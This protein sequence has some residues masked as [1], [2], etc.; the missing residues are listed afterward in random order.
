MSALPDAWCHKHLSLADKTNFFRP[1]AQEGSSHRH[2]PNT[3]LASDLEL[4]ELPCSGATPEVT[5]ELLLVYGSQDFPPGKPHLGNAAH[6]FV[7]NQGW[8]CMKSPGVYNPIT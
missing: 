6:R 2:V 5:A 3:C 4:P 1:Q 8:A 7:M